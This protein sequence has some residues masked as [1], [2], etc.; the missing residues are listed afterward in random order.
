MRWARIVVVVVGSAWFFPVSC[1]AS[2]FAGTHLVA[3]LDARDVN[4]GESVHSRFSMVIESGDNGEPF[5]VVNLDDL[6]FVQEILKFSDTTDVVSFLMSKP[7]GHLN[8]DGSRFS[9]QVID[10]TA[11]G[12]IIEV[13]E[14]YHD[15]DN[16]TWSRYKATHSTITPISSRMFYFGYIFTAVPYAIGLALLLYVMGRFLRR[17][18][19]Q[20][21]LVNGDP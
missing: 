19:Q 16:T 18:N 3:K 21:G 14:T 11:S 6:A 20:S 2:L 17:R 5:Q 1:T 4:K 7:S 12:Q 13:V 10:D 8:S 9:Y 15:G